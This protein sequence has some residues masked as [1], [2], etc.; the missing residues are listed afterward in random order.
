MRDAIERDQ[1]V[2]VSADEAYATIRVIEAALTS[3][4]MGCRIDLQPAAPPVSR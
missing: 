4:A 1:P 3:S 2:P